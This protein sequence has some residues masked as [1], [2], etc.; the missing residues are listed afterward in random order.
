MLSNF[1]ISKF[2]AEVTGSSVLPPVLIIVGFLVGF[3]YLISRRIKKYGVR[4]LAED[5]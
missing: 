1:W 3:S 2:H 4:Q 5:I